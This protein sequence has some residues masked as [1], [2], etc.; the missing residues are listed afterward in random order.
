MKAAGFIIFGGKVNNGAWEAYGRSL[1]REQKR[2]AARSFWG[3]DRQRKKKKFMGKER[4][5]LPG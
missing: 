3:R 2:R 4:E 1:G 5:E